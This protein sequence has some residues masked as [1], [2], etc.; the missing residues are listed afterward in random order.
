[1]VSYL[2]QLCHIEFKMRFSRL[3]PLDIVFATSVVAA[4]VALQDRENLRGRNL[5]L[6]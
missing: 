5:S 4:V 2:S 1:M 6:A 3:F